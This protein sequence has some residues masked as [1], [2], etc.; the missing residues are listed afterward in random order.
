MIIDVRER[1]LRGEHPRTEITKAV[2]EA[3]VGTVF[4]IH[5]PHR[6]EPLLS[7]L[8]GMGLN[9]I[10]NQLEENRDSS[11][12]SRLAR[13]ELGGQR[14]RMVSPSLPVAV[15]TDNASTLW[16]PSASFLGPKPSSRDDL[17]LAHSDCFFRAATVRSVLLVYHFEPP[18]AP[19]LTR[20]V[21]SSTPRTFR[22]GEAHR[23]IPVAKAAANSSE[24]PVT[25]ASLRVF[26]NPPDHSAQSWIHSEGL[27]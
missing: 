27:P 20:S 16:R 22:L 15:F 21:S 10:V 11:F 1:I 25:A 23:L 19:T 3:P 18:F 12:A 4:E 6:A 17:S 7:A 5:L 24:R 2:K 14:S 26:C 8:E 9:V 13:P